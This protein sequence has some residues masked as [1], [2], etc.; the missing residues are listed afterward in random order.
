[1]VDTSFQG[2][3]VLLAKGPAIEDKVL[4][5]SPNKCYLSPRFIHPPAAGGEGR[6]RRPPIGFGYQKVGANWPRRPS[7]PKYQLS[8]TWN[9]QSKVRSDVPRRGAEKA[10]ARVARLPSSTV[11]PRV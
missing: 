9:S 1:M 2:M 8:W 6:N 3:A 5:M 4:P 11:A 10:V 7:P